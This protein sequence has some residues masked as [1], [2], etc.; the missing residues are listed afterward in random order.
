[1]DDARRRAVPCSVCEDG[2]GRYSAMCPNCSHTVRLCGRC[3]AEYF[4][5]RACGAP[6]EDDD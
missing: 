3:F 6:V 4:D 2:V 1:M 5:C